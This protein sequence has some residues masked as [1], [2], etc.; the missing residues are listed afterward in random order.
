MLNFPAKKLFG[1]TDKEVIEKRTT[2]LNGDY[3]FLIKM[4]KKSKKNYI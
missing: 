2:Q 1:K 3:D 4:N